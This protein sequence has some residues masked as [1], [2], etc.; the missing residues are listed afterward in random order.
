[1]A[2]MVIITDPVDDARVF[3]SISVTIQMSNGSF[4]N[5]DSIGQA[6]QIN[7][8]KLTLL[9]LAIDQWEDMKDEDSGPCFPTLRGVDIRKIIFRGVVM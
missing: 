4:Q 5:F 2:Q 9:R 1:M 3:L 7:T 6:V 8:P